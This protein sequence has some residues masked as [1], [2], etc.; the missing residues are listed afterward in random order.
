MSFLKLRTRDLGK[1]IPLG[2]V[3][4]QRKLAT[5]AKPNS[6]PDIHFTRLF[7]NN[8]FVDAKSGKTFETLNPASGKPI[9]RI[10]EADS[11]DV[12]LAVKA[13]KEAFKLGSP[14]RR[15]DGAYRGFLLNK[16]ADL[17]ERDAAHLAALESLDNG[18]PY[19]IALNVDV[20][21]SI[22]NLR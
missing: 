17:M 12:D 11:T 3:S 21:G 1:L 14:W 18:K 10:A 4:L 7:I 22:A 16:L 15:S 13:A 20:P 19:H 6:N 9:A 8:E 2:R 5:S